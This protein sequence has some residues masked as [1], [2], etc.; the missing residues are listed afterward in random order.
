MNSTYCTCVYSILLREE[1]LWSVWLNVD[2]DLVLLPCLCVET[3]EHTNKKGSFM[4]LNWER[5]LYMCPRSMEFYLP[6]SLLK[7]YSLPVPCSSHPWGWWMEQ[8]LGADGTSFRSRLQLPFSPSLRQ[9]NQL[10]PS[11]DPEATSCQLCKQPKSRV[12]SRK[13]VNVSLIGK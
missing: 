6:Y 9:L 11:Q 2:I 10:A 3:L 7:R 4:K 12:I 8:Y 5:C 1:N 13:M